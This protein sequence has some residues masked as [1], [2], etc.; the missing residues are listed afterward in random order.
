[1]AEEVYAALAHH[2][3]VANDKRARVVG[4]WSLQLTAQAVLNALRSNVE[5]HF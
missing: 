5:Q 4:L 3:Q 2:V 1:L